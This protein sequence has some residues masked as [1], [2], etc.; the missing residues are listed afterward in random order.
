MNNTTQWSYRIPFAVQWVWPVPLLILILFAPESP[1][2]LA[3]KNRMVD[4]E[5]SLRRLSSRSPEELNGTLSQI[6]Y[7]TRLEEE[8]ESGGSYLDCFKGID[9]RRT[10]ICC[11]I[12]A[13]Q[14]LSGAQFAYGPTY[15]F[16]MAGMSVD[17]AYAVGVCS[18]ALAFLGTCFSWVLVTY[19]GRRSI[20]LTGI[21]GMAIV[22]LIIGVISASSTSTGGLWAQA[23]LCLV[24]QLIYSLSVGP[25]C[26]AIISETSAVRLR[27]KT[28]V[29][30]RNTYNIVT[31]GS[32]VLEPYMMNPTEWNWK[33]KTAFF[34]CGT[35]AL[36]ALWTFF[37][38]P[39]CKV[40]LLYNVSYRAQ[41]STY[42][43]I[44]DGRTRSWMFFL[45]SVFRRGSLRLPRSMHMQMRTLSTLL[46]CTSR[47]RGICFGRRSTW[48]DVSHRTRCCVMYL[49]AE[50]DYFNAFYTAFCSSHCQRCLQLGW[51]RCAAQLPH[52]SLRYCYHSQ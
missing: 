48:M 6:I 23:S 18:T 12:F 40:S 17:N 11:M 10:E 25:V 47:L 14:M 35:A 7:T 24:W 45:P 27:A 19:F 43:G 5:K 30:A 28:V 16:E 34:W 46:L 21:T 4:A 31:V 9:L 33:G 13:G 51:A 1:W 3:R 36:T 20:Y 2:W 44:R 32:L 39:E 50:T 37:R 41:A 26:Y 8:L 29:L 49:E 52:F 42:M 38:L 15:F 22:I